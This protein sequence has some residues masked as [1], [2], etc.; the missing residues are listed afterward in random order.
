MNRLYKRTNREVTRLKSVIKVIASVLLFFG[1]LFGAAGIFLAD[2]T[3]QSSYAVAIAFGTGGLL[4]MIWAKKTVY[5]WGLTFLATSGTLF[6]SVIVYRCFHASEWAMGIGFL[7]LDAS[8][9][10]LAVFTLLACL[11]GKAPKKI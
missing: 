9:L 11:R 3:E 10:I 6:F 2:H 8:L 1:F 4:F 5:L 7:C